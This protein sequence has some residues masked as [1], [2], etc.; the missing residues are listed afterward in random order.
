MTPAAG[1]A[2]GR[3]VAQLLVA[4][5]QVAGRAGAGVRGV[6]SAFGGLL[7]GLP[8]GAPGFPAALQRAFYRTRMHADAEMLPGHSGQIRLP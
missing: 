8:G 4:R 3:D 5:D 7:P 2:A 1:V 6:G